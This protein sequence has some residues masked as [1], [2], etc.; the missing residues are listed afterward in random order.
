MKKLQRLQKKKSKLIV[1]L[2]SGTSVDGIDA[3]IVR[4]SG[5]GTSTRVQQIAYDTYEYPREFRKTVLSNSLPGTGNVDLLT[6]LNVL[7]AHFFADAVKRIARKARVPLADINLIGSHGQTMHH[8]PVPERLYGKTIRSTLQLGDPSTIAQLTGVTT[9][10]DFRMA[11]MAQGGQGAPLVPYLDYLLFRSKTKNRI[12]LNL[13]GIANF[14]M[15]PKNCSA[16]DVI[17]FDTGPANMIIDGLM[18][19][20]YGK[21]YDDGGKIGMQGKVLPKLLSWLMSHPYFKRRPPKSTGRELYGSAFLERLVKKGK[22]AKKEDLIATAAA[23]TAYSIYDQYRRFIQRRMRVDEV[24]ASGGGIYNQ[25]IM[26]R[27]EHYFSQA[28]VMTL[29]DVGFSPDAKEAICFAVL[30][31]ETIAEQPS[32]VPSVTGARKAAILGKICL[33]D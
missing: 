29:E 9:I 10:G 1:G 4:V 28:K 6:R 7:I 11:D 19:R 27:L 20:F 12:L 25:A 15:L 31:N 14:T 22:R 3:A 33:P 2:I 24:L 16:S 18:L 8:L 32:N 26:S 13:G 30:A 17:A 23:F 21:K 5:N